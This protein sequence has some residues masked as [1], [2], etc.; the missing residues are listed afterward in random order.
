[1][2]GHRRHSRCHQQHRQPDQPACPQCSHRGSPGR[3]GGSRLLGGGGRDQIL[4]HQDPVLHR[5]NP[6]D[7]HPAAGQCRQCR[8]G[9]G[10]RGRA[11][12]QLPAEG[13]RHRHHTAADQQHVAAGRLRQ[14]P[15]SPGR[16]GT[17]PG[18]CRYRSQR[19]QHQ[20]P[21]R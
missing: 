18:H 3:R 17:I 14:Q 10:E 11:L 4:G 15:D 19:A 21:G 6:E 7:D 5:R 2:P 1:M 9:D 20:D 8:T 16:A 13:L 12:R